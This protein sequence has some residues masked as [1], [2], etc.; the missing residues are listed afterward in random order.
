MFHKPATGLN[1]RAHKMPVKLKTISN[2][3]KCLISAKL[4]M[5]VAILTTI[6]LS[7]CK[8]GFRHSN[9][10]HI[11]QCSFPNWPRTNTIRLHNLDASAKANEFCEAD[12][13]LPEMFGSQSLSH[14]PRTWSLCM[15]LIVVANWNDSFRTITIKPPF[16]SN[17]WMLLFWW[18]IWGMHEI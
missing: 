11:L 13:C 16:P 4:K 1:E 9:K 5:Y 7:P 3:H 2:Y 10:A 15:F 18:F 12:T 14:M 8:R 6:Q 17:A